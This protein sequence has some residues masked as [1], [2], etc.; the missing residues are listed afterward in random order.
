MG[1][2]ALAPPTNAE[3]VCSTEGLTN[4]QFA[5]VRRD[6]GGIGGSDAAAVCGLNPYKSRYALWVECLNGPEPIEDPKVLE[7]M[8]LGHKLE[9]VIADLFTERTGLTVAEFP[10]L[11]RHPEHPW[12]TANI[13]RLVVPEDDTEV[14]VLEVK[15]TGAHMASGWDTE[16]VPDHYML[17]GQHYL[18]V[19]G[20]P[21]VWFAVLI[22]GDEVRTVRVER[23]DNLISDLMEIEEAFVKLVET[24]TPPATDG[25][26]ATLKALARRFEVVPK[27]EVELDVTTVEMVG[28]LLDRMDDAKALTREIDAIKALLME[29]MGENE[30]GTY[31][32]DTV[33][34]WKQATRT[35]LDT[36]ALKRA[37]PDLFAEFQKT[38]TYRR[39]LPKGAS[40]D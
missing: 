19:T 37:F 34:T 25:S 10:Y 21:V 36:A 32:G 4:D 24:K 15:K 39:F 18:G 17:Q 11:L 13:D 7:R 35:A 38:T 27:S 40:N 3:V 23:D 30:I 22:G 14:A 28:D 9:P 20:L 8:E 26:E 6:A 33:L 16:K 12:M 31:E 5:Q 2:M 29:G 1:G